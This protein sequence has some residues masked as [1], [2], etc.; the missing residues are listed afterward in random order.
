M[1]VNYLSKS[2][3][4]LHKTWVSIIWYVPLRDL[5]D[6]LGFYKE[7]TLNIARHYVSFCSGDETIT[8]QKRLLHMQRNILELSKIER[9]PNYS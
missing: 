1:K 5:R 9:K 6:I 3:L 4:H 7:Q 2:H 8:L